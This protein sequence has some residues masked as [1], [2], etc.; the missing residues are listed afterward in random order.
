MRLLFAPIIT[1]SMPSPCPECGHR[2]VH[3]EVGSG[4]C[5]ALLYPQLVRCPCQA[6][7]TRP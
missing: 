7:N 4:G 2:D 1:A 3:G 6:E 5:A